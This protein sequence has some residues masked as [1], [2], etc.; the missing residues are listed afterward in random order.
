[1]VESILGEG[2]LDTY[3]KELTGSLNRVV[4]SLNQKMLG[5]DS[6]GP[7]AESARG[8]QAT[9]ENLKQATGR[10]N[11]LLQRSAP[12]L[13]STLAN[14][15]QLT[16]TLEQQRESIA[17]I[18][19]NADSLSNQ[20]VEAQLDEAIEGVKA[21]IDQLNKTLAGADTAVAGLNQVM[22]KIENG[23]GTLGMLVQ[24]ETLYRNLNALTYSL[25]SLTTDL[26]E[27]PYRYLPLKSRNRVKRYDRKDETADQ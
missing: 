20:L 2:G 7:L 11:L 23:E 8:I 3:M 24:D 1:M 10:M 13:E 15:D 5:E 16:E 9:V 17:G 27:R 19:N 12:A 6:E 21:T 26:Q 14:I 22:G 4:D 18:L 25:D